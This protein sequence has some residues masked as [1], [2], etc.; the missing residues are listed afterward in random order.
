MCRV[1]F[2]LDTTPSLWPRNAAKPHARA[3]AVFIDKLY[4]RCFQS[5]TNSEVICGGH[6]GPIVDQFGAPDG[7][8]P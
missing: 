2:S 8:D 4:P 1:L 3:A 5:T 6:G 7:I